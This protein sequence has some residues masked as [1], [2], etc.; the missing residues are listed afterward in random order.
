MGYTKGCKHLI[1]SYVLYSD[2]INK[3]NKHNNGIFVVDNPMDWKTSYCLPLM[4][5]TFG[6]G[7]PVNFLEKPLN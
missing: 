5:V 2:Q 6:N 3:E 4:V 1:L 7:E